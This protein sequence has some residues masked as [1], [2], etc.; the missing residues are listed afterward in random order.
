MK[1]DTRDKIVLMI[2][3]FTIA[4]LIWAGYNAMACVKVMRLYEEAGG[5]GW[6]CQSCDMLEQAGIISG[7]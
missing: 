6:I 1:L 5:Y 2:I 4:V 7:G 3:L